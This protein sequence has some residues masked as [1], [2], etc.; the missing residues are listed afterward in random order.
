M[1]AICIQVVLLGLLQAARATPT[2]SWPV[3]PRAAAAPAMPTSTLVSDFQ[4]NNISSQWAEGYPKQWGAEDAKF[5]IPMPVPD[6]SGLSGSVS[7]DEKF[8]AMVNNTDAKILRLDT[9]AIVSAFSLNVGGS[10]NRAILH[11]AP[12]GQYDLVVAVE[13]YNTRT[14]K[15][16]RFRLS[17]DGVPSN[18]TIQYNGRFSSFDDN[19][20]S[21]DGRRFLS[22]DMTTVRSGLAY[23]YDLDNLSYNLTLSNQSDWVMSAAFSP[24]GRYIS[25]A[26][27]DG[28]AKLYN[29][30]TGDV[31]HTFA[32][33][34]GQNWLTNF[35][36]DGKYVLFSIGP[37]S[38]PSPGI[39][40]IIYE[41]D[42]LSADP[43]FFGGYHQWVRST[44]WSPDSKYL[45]AGSYGELH[46]YRLS[47][48]KII[49]TWELEDQY[50]WELNNLLWLDNGKRL[51]Y[52]ITGGLEMYDFETNLKYRW[53]PGDLDHY[54][55]GSGPGN[56]WILKSKGWIG[57]VDSDSRIRFWKYPA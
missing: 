9:G 28:S 48:R 24:D 17:K 47:D 13:D 19:P 8:L 18:Q 2:I 37:G 21:K 29:A 12:G 10:A 14:E 6:S 51:A 20:F 50:T 39:G 42:D 27:W 36:P 49:Q 3:R 41:L 4:K 25:T 54:N 32:P 5:E 52:R 16:L 1:V 30:S 35:S 44:A 34:G 43:I 22:I 38:K 57:G 33:T 23:A 56:T 31:V 46:I 45:V 55:Y 53:G 11:S 15:T 26:A 40:V 7:P